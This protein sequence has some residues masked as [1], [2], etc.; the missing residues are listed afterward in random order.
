MSMRT[1]YDY[2][3]VGAGSAGCVLAARLTEDPTVRV[4]LIEAGGTDAVANVQVPIAF[5]KLFGTAADWGYPVK[6]EHKLDG[7]LDKALTQFEGAAQKIAV[8]FIRDAAVRREY[9]RQ[10]VEISKLVRSE[11]TSGRVGVAEGVRFAQTLL[12][13]IM[14][15]TRAATSVGTLAIVERYKREGRS[16]RFLLEKYSVQLTDASSKQMTTQELNA[17]V[18]S[19]V[20]GRAPSVFKRLTDEQRAKV[21]YSIIDA[22]GRDSV[23]Y[24]AIS[25]NLAVAGKV[26]TV[27]TAILAIYQISNTDDKVQETNRQGAIFGGSLLGGAL[28]G[29][30]ASLVCG[31]GAPVCAFVFIAA[32]GLAGANLA[33]KGN[34]LYQAELQEFMKWKIR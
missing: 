3:I 4:A 33:E 25:K 28:G 10:I 32:G 19:I 30:A 13:Q 22:A 5:P 9:M 8:D 29:A 18:Q 21:Y 26:F 12:N 34:D 6:Q 20:E 7:L 14:M 17:Y 31:P 2:V 15:E 1:A 23:K 16:E 11:V 24:T 27:M